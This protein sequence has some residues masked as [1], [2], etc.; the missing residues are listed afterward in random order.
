MKKKANSGLAGEMAQSYKGQA[1]DQNT[2]NKLWLLR[3]SVTSNC[4][5]PGHCQTPSRVHQA[6][7]G[8]RNGT[9]NICKGTR[10]RW[11][12][13]SVKGTWG[14]DAEKAMM[15]GEQEQK[16]GEGR[17]SIWKITAVSGLQL[18][19]SP[20]SHQLVAQATAIFLLLLINFICTNVP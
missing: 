8:W 7:D 9:C 15:G 13:S 16:S 4:L 12:A 17:L 5:Q 10:S 1:H 19:Q 3:S 14:G 6:V 20:M 11:A 18:P 2:K